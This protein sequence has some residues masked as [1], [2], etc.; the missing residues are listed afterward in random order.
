MPITTLILDIDDTLYDVGCG[1]TA[2]RNGDSVTAFMVAELGFT[3]PVSARALRDEYFQRYHST[4]KALTMAEGDGR[5]PTG[6]HFETPMLSNWWATKLDFERYLSP[7]AALIE[8]LR[9][10]PLTLVAFSNAPRRYAIRCLETLG[11]REFFPDERV[12]AV[13]DVL[14]ACKPEPA[15][16]EKVLG[17]IGAAAHECVFVDDSMKN[18]RAAKALGIGTVLVTGLGTGDAAA[19]EATKPGDAP[20]A[21]DPAADAVVPSPSHMRVALPG[22]WRTP[23]TF[24]G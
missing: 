5:L 2:H 24:P 18:I 8:S 10:C 14:P 23:A 12:F 15:A 11:L 22:L 4:A 13:D 17:A 19:S 9:A 21:N 1:F 3:D 16:F 6:A 20:V 7:D